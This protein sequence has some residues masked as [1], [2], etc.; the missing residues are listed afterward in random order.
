MQATRIRVVHQLSVFFQRFTHI[1]HQKLD[2]FNNP[3]S[4]MQFIFFQRGEATEE[5][6]LSDRGFRASGT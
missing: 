3:L 5:M 2:G 4:Q 1:T 6:E